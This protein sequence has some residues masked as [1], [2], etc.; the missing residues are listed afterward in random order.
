MSKQN[1]S[2]IYLWYDGK[3]FYL[4]V[5]E[6]TSDD[7][8]I[9]SSKVML[10]E[11]EKRPQ[12]FR[13]R[14]LAYGTYKE[15][16]DLEIKLLTNIKEKGRWDKYYNIAF[17]FPR[18]CHT[19]ETVKKISK[20]LKGIPKSEE[21]KRKIGEA[22]KGIPKS[23]EHKRKISEAKKGI[24]SHFLGKTHTEEAKRKIS[25]AKKGIPRSEETKRKI[26]EKSKGRKHTEETKRKI[27]E[28]NKGQNNGNSKTNRERRVRE[29]KA[30]TALTK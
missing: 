12:D 6:G 14:I 29:K 16:N 4:G 9:C 24:T 7:G 19:E 22:K 11:Y 28:A 18:M 2:F 3:K 8:Y 27:S 30:E 1:T 5:H 21:H 13:R 23:E 25:E 20:G 17:N 10:E 15:M 26:S